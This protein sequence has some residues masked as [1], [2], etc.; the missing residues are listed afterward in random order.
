MSRLIN[1]HALRVRHW[2]VAHLHVRAKHGRS[3]GFDLLLGLVLPCLSLIVCYEFFYAFTFSEL[4]DIQ[5]AEIKSTGCV[6]IPL[7]TKQHPSEGESQSMNR[8][9]DSSCD[10]QPDRTA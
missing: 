9:R 6:E 10:W 7:A 4:V 2:S 8:S 3:T 1:G 5:Q